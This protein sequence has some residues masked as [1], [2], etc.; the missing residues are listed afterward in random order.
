MGAQGQAASDGLN[1][2]LAAAR[3]EA[4]R[5]I[6]EEIRRRMATAA[7]RLRDSPLAAMAVQVGDRAPGFALPD[8][9]GHTV[10][11]EDL[12]RRGPV[13][14]SFYRGGWCPFCSIEMAH[15]ARARE[16]IERAGAHIVAISPQTLA[17]SKD[18]AAKFHPGFP[19]LA[20]EGGVVA[21]AYGLRYD[22]DADLVAAYRSFGVDLPAVNG[23]DRWSLPVPATYVIGTDGIVTAAHVNTDYT[24]R[25]EPADIIRALERGR[26]ADA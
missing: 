14:L 22:L 18:S 1:A 25:M 17:A 3:D 21:D 2:A 24:T 9:E 5:R 20:D 15:L 19:L 11:L 10:R 6:P 23:E 7:A 16:A 13:V 12:L 8:T 26:A 4:M